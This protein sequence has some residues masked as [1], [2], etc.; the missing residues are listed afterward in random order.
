MHINILYGIID[1]IHFFPEFDNIFSMNYIWTLLTI[2]TQR[3][4]CVIRD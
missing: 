2:L 4:S 3:A 1:V